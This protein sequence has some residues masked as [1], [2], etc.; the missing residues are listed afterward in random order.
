M[1]VFSGD[2]VYQMAA[3]MEAAGQQ[4]YEIVA[5]ECPNTVVAELCRHLG[6]QEAAHYQT[7]QDMRQALVDRPP[8]RP[9]TW[10]EIG[11]AQMLVEERVVPDEAEARRMAAESTLD[12]VLSTAIEMEKDSILFYA[13]MLEAVDEGD[14]HA[15]RQIIHEEKHHLTDLVAARKKSG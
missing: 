9:L 12:D 8:S 15:I 11:F 14:E 13:E 10:D 4:F 7:F 2:E 1:A 3:Q 5:A 6:A